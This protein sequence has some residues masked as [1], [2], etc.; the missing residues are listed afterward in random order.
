MET[1]ARLIEPSARYFIQNTLQNCH[2]TRVR[3]YSFIFNI[4]VFVIFFL[5]FGGILYYSYKNK[6]TEYE[7]RQ[8]MLRDQE[9]ILSKIRYYQTE[10]H[11]KYSSDITDLPTTTNMM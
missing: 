11:K 1:T 2:S 5:V 7:K 10:T 3:I 8:K 9:Y 6:P 4:V